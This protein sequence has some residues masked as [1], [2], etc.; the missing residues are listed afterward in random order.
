MNKYSKSKKSL[1][2][3]L[4]IN[5]GLISFVFAQT[6]QSPAYISPNNDGVKDNL[7]LPLTVKDKRYISEWHFYI[8]DASGKVVRTI[9]NKENRPV[10]LSFSEFWRIISTPKQS[11]AVPKNLIWDGKLDSGETAPD[12]TYYYSFEASD[13]NGNMQKTEKLPVVVKCAPP[14]VT[15]TQPSAAEKFFGEGSKTTLRIHETGSK[16]DLWTASINDNTGNAVRTWKLSNSTPLEIVWDGRDDS[17]TLVADGVYNYSIKSTDKAGNKSAP[18]G[19]TNIIYSGEKPLSNIAVNGSRYFSP[20]TESLQKSITLVPTVP[21][22]ESGNTLQNWKVEIVD[23]RNTVYKTYSGGGNVPATIDFNGLDEN[24]KVL[25]DG[26]YYG[27]ITASYLNGYETQ[28]KL[29]PEL[30]LKREKPSGTARAKDLVFAPGGAGNKSTLT[31]T[32]KLSAEETPWKGEILDSKNTVV[33]SFDLGTRPKPEIVWNGMN[34]SGALCPD[35]TYTY[36]A[37]CTDLAGNYGLV[38]SEAAFV[39]DT[40]KVDLMLSLTPE[41][42]SPNGDSVQDKIKFIPQSSGTVSDYTLEVL[43][44]ASRIVYTITNNGELPAAIEWDGKETGGNIAADG[45]YSARLTVTKATNSIPSGV[46]SQKFTLDTVA[47]YASIKS[48]YLVFCPTPDSEKS[49][50]PFVIE[51][52]KA[53]KLWTGIITNTS[54][55]TLRTFDWYNTDVKPFAWD[56]TDDSGNVCPDGV[57]TFTLTS[58]DAAGNKG[59]AEL[60]GI[61]IDKRPARAWVTSAYE[62][63]APNGRTKQQSFTTSTSLKDGAASWSFGIMNTEKPKD[64]ALKIWSGEGDTLPLNFDWDGKTPDGKAIAEG[65][66]AGKLKIVYTKGISVETESPAF[67]CTGKAPEISINIS[68]EYFSPDNDGYDD[69]CNITLNKNSLLPFESWSFEVFDTQDPASTQKQEN[70]KVFW[71]VAGKSNITDK[72]VWDGKSNGRE[73]VQSAMDYPCMFTVTD[74]EGQVSSVRGVIR[75]DVLVVRDGDKLKMQ[76]PSIIFIADEG[77]YASKKND[78]RGLDQSIVDNNDRILKR[79][80]QILNKFKD[81]KVVIEGHSN[82]TTGSEEEET[83]ASPKWGKALKTLSESRA[84]FVLT[85]LTQMGVSKSRLD[86]LGMGGT[87][88]VAD[89]QDPNSRWKNRR[90]EFILEK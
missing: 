63:I 31:I 71:A 18:A 1:F 76:V 50:I 62:T 44:S 36:R 48:D 10:S 45:L 54:G 74:I 59:S 55:K 22:P 25:K 78:P 81:Y 26:S 52:S 84:R 77:Y 89:T 27:K 5:F 40:S 8:S 51:T 16:E 12:G 43:N 68:P 38:V 82:S 21:A 29:S 3:G 69:D 58:I 4:F 57:Y 88:P 14:V 9:S 15:L 60:K 32:E 83:N 56:G 85:R 66:F 6:G 80:A 24:G 41:Y 42:F 72:L 49:T 23:A 46:T 86:I 70:N 73:L 79:I 64:K 2:I 53:E 90:V 33:Q 37:Y 67:V 20:Q 47:P 19:I 28:A 87:K 65:I 17:G 11:V 30:I 75:V 35:G 13:D 7:V 34:S 39:I 61:T